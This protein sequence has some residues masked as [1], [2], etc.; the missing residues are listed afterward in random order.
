MEGRMKKTIDVAL[1]TDG[2]LDCVLSEDVF[3]RHYTPSPDEREKL[4]EAVDDFVETLACIL[5]V[6]RDGFSVD[7]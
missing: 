5:R 7:Q 2:I 6:N 1:I 3:D 4:E